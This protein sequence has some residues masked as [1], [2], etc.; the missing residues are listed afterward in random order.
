M[1]VCFRDT[2]LKWTSN[3]RQ[4]ALPL[5]YPSAINILTR[6]ASY[7]RHSVLGAWYS[8]F[9]AFHSLLTAFQ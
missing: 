7:Q 2:G 1:D 6:L 8:S 9:G 3:S 4:K 5:L